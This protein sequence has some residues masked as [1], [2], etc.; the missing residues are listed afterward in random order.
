MLGSTLMAASLFLPQVTGQLATWPSAFVRDFGWPVLSPVFALV[1]LSGVLSWARAGWA[2]APSSAWL[3]ALA[4]YIRRFA[5]S[6]PWQENL[7]EIELYLSPWSWFAAFGG[8]GCVLVASLRAALRVPAPSDVS[9]F[10]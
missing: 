6:F 10:D 9:A 4:W 3:L 1:A 8:G 2:W 5:V 7:F